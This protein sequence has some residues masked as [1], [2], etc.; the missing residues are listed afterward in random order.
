MSAMEEVRVDAKV[1]KS[2]KDK[3]PEPQAE[4][5]EDFQRDLQQAMSTTVMT[6]PDSTG[7]KRSNS[8]CGTD[9]D[10]CMVDEIPGSGVRVCLL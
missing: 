4:S 6:S 5:R 7:R 9:E 8:S 10:F 2:K 3:P 1:V